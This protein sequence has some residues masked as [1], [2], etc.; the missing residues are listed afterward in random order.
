MLTLPFVCVRKVGQNNTAWLCESKR[1]VYDAIIVWLIHRVMGSKV[2]E[3][4]G[5]V[6]TTQFRMDLAGLPNCP[7][8]KWH[9]VSAHKIAAF[10]CL[11][12]RNNAAFSSL[13]KKK[14]VCN[15]IQ[16][17]A[18]RLG[19][20]YM[21]WVNILVFRYS[22]LL[23]SRNFILLYGPIFKHCFVNVPVPFQG[24]TVW[25]AN[26]MLTSF[27]LSRTLQVW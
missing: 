12:P 18:S 22:V 15:S 1:C 3:E 13:K 9:T 6:Q 19:W 27:M 17:L 8:R 14:W 4:H 11:R 2:S 24:L 7:Q 10:F 5:V 26:A 20:N 23:D 21:V 25:A 16:H